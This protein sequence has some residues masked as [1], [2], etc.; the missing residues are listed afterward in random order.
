MEKLIEAIKDIAIKANGS[1]EPM[2]FLYGVAG[3][4]SLLRPPL[5]HVFEFL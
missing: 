1:T 2:G 5:R 3:R 4:F